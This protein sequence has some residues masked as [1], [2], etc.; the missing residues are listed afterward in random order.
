[1]SRVLF[2]LALFW[3][4]I[5]ML[6]YASGD[7]LASVRPVL[8]SSLDP[9]Q[10]RA[11]ISLARDL[12][13]RDTSRVEEALDDARAILRVDPL[14]PE[15]LVL[16]ARGARDKGDETLAVDLM[17]R[18]VRLNLRNGE[19]GLFLLDRAL[20]QGDARNAMAMMDILLRGQ[21]TLSM[22]PLSRAL[23]PIL[24]Q[25]P[26]AGALAATLA[27]RPPWRTYLLT[28][29]AV[30]SPDTSGLIR[31]FVVLQASDARPTTVELRPFLERLVR[32][33]RL[34]EARSV[35]IK[36]LPPER[37]IV[38]E[39]LYNGRFQFPLTNLPFD[40]VMSPINN[41]LIGVNGSGEGRILNVDFFGGRVAFHN[42]SHLLALKPGRYRLTGAER[43]EN[44]RSERGLWWR[45]S[46]IGKPEKTL[47]TTALLSGDTPWRE[48]S[49]DFDVPPDAC[50]Y[51]SL[52]LELPYRSAIE[53]EI[54]GGASYASLDIRVMSPLGIK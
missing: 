51:Q 13:F 49:V 19:A 17:R 41:T 36:T 27:A 25:D 46:C 38:G 28:H 35:W 24:T 31:L 8:A 32:E 30:D 3:C 33:G 20:R 34:D 23:A 53:Q 15:A 9:G 47:A 21:E 1:M 37:N 2:V 54:I 43:A 26:F 4:A 16:L 29:M 14:T 18:A 11:R 39:N 50:S 12:Y 44:L 22:D 48:F 10:T 45:V 6:R 7:L 5:D 40:W 52:V 42:V